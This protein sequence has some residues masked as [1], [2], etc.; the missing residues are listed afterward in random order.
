MLPGE[1]L[2]TSPPPTPCLSTQPVCTGHMGASEAEM[3]ERNLVQVLGLTIVVASVVVS[4]ISI[5]S[6]MMNPSQ[7]P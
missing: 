4:P 5:P 1:K 6:P 7:S 2:N 3:S